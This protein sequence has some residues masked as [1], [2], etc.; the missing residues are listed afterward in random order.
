MNFPLRAPNE[1]SKPPIPRVIITIEPAFHPKR[2][3]IMF[4]RSKGLKKAIIAMFK[5]HPRAPPKKP[6][7]NAQIDRLW[8]K[9]RPPRN[10]PRKANH[11]TPENSKANTKMAVVK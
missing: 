2:E 11:H 6:E 4:R 3:V 7:T 1:A 5:A 10:P 9:R 8:F